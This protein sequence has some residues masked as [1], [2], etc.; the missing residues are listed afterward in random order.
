MEFSRQEHWS[1]VLFPSPGDPPNPGIKPGSPALQADS[2]PF[3]P[4]GKPHFI[5]II[6]YIIND[7]Y[8]IQIIYMY[9]RRYCYYTGEETEPQRSLVICPRCN[10]LRKVGPRD[11]PSCSQ[12]VLVTREIR[13]KSVTTPCQALPALGWLPITFMR[14]EETD[15]IAHTQPLGPERTHP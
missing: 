1:G 7:T 9:P 8:M 6:N 3:E 5:C 13:Y 2:L 4:P 12:V 11:K 14:T 15:A 10:S